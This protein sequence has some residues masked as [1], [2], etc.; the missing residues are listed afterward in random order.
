MSRCICDR[1]SRSSSVAVVLALAPCFASSVTSTFQP[2]RASPTVTGSFTTAARY[3]KSSSSSFLRSTS[4]SAPSAPSYA[5]LSR[6]FRISSSTRCFTSCDVS[7]R[8]TGTVTCHLGGT[9]TPPV[10]RP[11]GILL[12]WMQICPGL[13]VSM[14]Q[15]SSVCV[16]V[17]TCVLCFTDLFR[18]LT[19]TTPSLSTSSGTYSS[20]SSSLSSRKCQGNIAPPSTSSPTSFPSMAACSSSFSSAFFFSASFSL[21]HSRCRSSK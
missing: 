15:R 14:Q 10:A 3:T 9:T 17:W 11:S 2:M 13:H 21:S 12:P 6:R 18:L 5:P 1:S 7:S 16:C 8:R 4:G 20:S 19:M